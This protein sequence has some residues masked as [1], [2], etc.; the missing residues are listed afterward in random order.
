MRSIIFDMCWKVCQLSMERLNTVECH[1]NA[2]HC[3]IL[4]HAALQ[5]LREHISEFVL[6][7]DIP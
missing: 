2:T 3:D 5:K 6:T 1:Y 4:L 7:K